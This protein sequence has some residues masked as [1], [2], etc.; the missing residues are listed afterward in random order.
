MQTIQA[1]IEASGVSRRSFLRFCAGLAATASAGLGLTHTADAETIAKR[2]GSARRPSIVWLEFADCTGC[3]ESLLHAEDPDISELLFD[4]ISLVYHET[5]MAAAGRQA[6]TSLEQAITSNRGSY[7]LVVE[8]A[9]PSGPSEGYAQTAGRSGLEILRRAAQDAAFVIAIGSCASWGGVVAAVPNPSHSISVGD[10]VQDKTLINLPGC[11]PHPSVLLA[12]L[13]EYAAM[14]RLPALD[15]ANRP[16][17]AYDRLIHEDCPRRGHFDAGRFVQTFGDEGHRSGWCLYKLGCKGPQTHA[18]CS[19]RHFNGI[20]NAWPVGIGA[21]CIG[22][23]EQNVGFHTPIFELAN[24]HAATPAE[25]LPPTVEP[26]RTGHTGAAVALGALAG[27]AGA[28]AWFA[29][30]RL[31]GSVAHTEEQEIEELEELSQLEEEPDNSRLE[32][33]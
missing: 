7:V 17:F 22:C 1:A 24:L 10:A 12:V 25:A 3:T 6:E 27:A 18:A 20:P 32:H 4:L 16:R 19:T 23:A 15:H 8:G 11:P 31:P 14:H 28:A 9:I 5:L 30:R 2:I 26:V 33:K 13:L 21:P 29:S